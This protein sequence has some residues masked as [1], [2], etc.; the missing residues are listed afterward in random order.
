MLGYCWVSVVDDVT[1]INKHWVNVLCLL[2]NG[3]KQLL[4]KYN[5]YN[6]IF[7]PFQVVSRYLYFFSLRANILK[8]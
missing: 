2:G 8:S 3:R 1:T 4:N 7:H 5:K 6:L